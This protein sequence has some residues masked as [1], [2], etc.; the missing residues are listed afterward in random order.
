LLTP[1]LADKPYDKVFAF[2]GVNFPEI[3]QALPL[4]K[5]RGIPV[6]GTL[7]YATELYPI[8]DVVKRFESSFFK[9]T[10][11]YMLAYALYLD[12]DMIFI[13]GIGGRRRWDYE[14]GKHYILFWLGIA[15][16]IGVDVR[17]G[18]G[19]SKWLYDFT[20]LDAPRPSEEDRMVWH[21]KT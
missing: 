14:I 3:A 20:P 12:K 17:I 6:L 11:S 18:P 10:L 19:S 7:D 2:D 16:G 1:G 13:H 5:S 4:A 9:N 8:R 21:E 15:R